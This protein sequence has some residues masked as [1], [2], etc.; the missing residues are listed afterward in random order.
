MTIAIFFI[1]AASVSLI[2]SVL[3]GFPKQGRKRSQEAGEVETRSTATPKAQMIK[4][5]V[6]VFSVVSLASVALELILS[7]ILWILY[8]FFGF[9]LMLI[10]LPLLGF[11]HDMKGFFEFYEPF[12][13]LNYLVQQF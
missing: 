2:L 6:V 5:F 7:F 8:I 1:W 12:M 10:G 13:I 3:E 9:L 11:P 4:D